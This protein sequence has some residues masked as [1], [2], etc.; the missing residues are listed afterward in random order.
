[1]CEQG[2]CPDFGP[3]SVPRDPQ[4]KP[5]LRCLDLQLQHRGCR[6]SVA[7]L[8]WKTEDAEL[9]EAFAPFGKLVE[10]RVAVDRDEG[11]SRGFGFVEF[12]EPGCAAAALAQMDGFGLGGRSIRVKLH[13]AKKKKHGEFSE[14]VK[15]FPE[16][17]Q[18]LEKGSDSDDDIGSMGGGRGAPKRAG[19]DRPPGHVEESAADYRSS[20]KYPKIF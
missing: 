16:M 15:K 1:M 13:K 20:G 4:A 11:R 19:P 8:S 6:A 14:I 9:R 12:E 17:A 10:A 18:A 3:P 5:N 7:G 2:E